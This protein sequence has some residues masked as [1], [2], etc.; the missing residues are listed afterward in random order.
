[1]TMNDHDGEEDGFRNSE[2]Q[3]IYHNFHFSIKKIGGRIS[4]M[5]DYDI[6][7]PLGQFYYV[8]QRFVKSFN[9]PTVYKIFLLYMNIPNDSVRNLYF[10]F[11][12]PS[13]DTIS[14]PRFLNFCNLIING[15]FHL[16]KCWI[17]LLLEQKILP[18][19]IEVVQ[20]LKCLEIKLELVEIKLN[21][22]I[23]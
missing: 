8:K 11:K 1:M 7:P 14:L 9:S 12:C 6:S 22:T 5:K 13:T 21:S 19:H 3:S 15:I 23:F 4:F 2:T 17:A 10:V 16:R 18:T 20:M